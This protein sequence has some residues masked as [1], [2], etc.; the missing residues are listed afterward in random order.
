MPE[1]IQI[2]VNSHKF[3]TTQK[4]HVLGTVFHVFVQFLDFMSDD[5][6]KQLI[7]GG[8]S[9]MVDVGLVNTVTMT[10]KALK[11]QRIVDNYSREEALSYIIDSILSAEGL[12]TLP[13]FG[14]AKCDKKETGGRSI[15]AV[16][17]IN[18]E[19]TLLRTLD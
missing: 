4:Q 5:A 14:V 8:T 10:R 1:E 19:K 17:N 6:I 3:H 12:S 15:R 2:N 13:G 18:P 9:L 16:Y 7:R 11:G